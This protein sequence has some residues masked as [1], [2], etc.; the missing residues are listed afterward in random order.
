MVL[1]FP[2]L[3]GGALSPQKV[4]LNCLKLGLLLRAGK[5]NAKVVFPISAASPALQD[6]SKI[7]G[8][9]PTAGLALNNKQMACSPFSGPAESTPLI[10]SLHVFEPCFYPTG[11]QP[12][13]SAGLVSSGHRTQGAALVSLSLISARVAASSCKLRQQ[14]C[15][16]PAPGAAVTASSPWQLRAAGVRCS[17]AAAMLISSCSCVLQAP[18]ELP[19]Q[20]P[21]L[22]PGAEVPGEMKAH[23]T[24]S[25]PAWCS[26]PAAWASTSRSQRPMP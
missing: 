8:S 3:L 14:N 2:F 11:R 15:F 21:P 26:H 6:L 1:C 20:H 10:P 19:R 23:I 7:I 4:C 16:L 18:G 25:A 17:R 12:G 5:S 22:Q 13:S 24:V 9:G